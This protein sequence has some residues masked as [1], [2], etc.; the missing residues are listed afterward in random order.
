[1]NYWNFWTG[2]DLRACSFQRGV[3]LAKWTAEIQASPMGI[4]HRQCNEKL[5]LLIDQSNVQSEESL[6]V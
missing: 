2:R 5:P 6:I 3:G 4:F 1:M